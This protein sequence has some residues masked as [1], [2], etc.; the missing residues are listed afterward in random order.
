MLLKIFTK[1]THLKLWSFLSTTIF[2]LY[3]IAH[4]ATTD[5]ITQEDDAI[6]TSFKQF[7]GD[8]YQYKRKQLNG[9]LSNNTQYICV[10]NEHTYVVR[11]LKEPLARRQNEINTHLLA[12]SKGIAPK[13]YYYDDAFSCVILDFIHDHTLLVEQAKRY[14]VLDIIAKKV[15]L[16]TQFDVDILANHHEPD[17]FA[18]IVADYNQIKDCGHTDFNALIDKA[19]HD[20]EII[21]HTLERTRRPSVFNHNDLHPRNIFFTQ[22][23]ILIIDWETAAMNYEFYDLACYSVYSCLNEAED[24]YLLTQYLQ[25]CPSDSDLKEYH[26]VKLMLRVFMAFAFLKLLKPMPQTVPM[27]AVKEFEYYMQ[28][29]A[30]DTNANSPE[31]LYALAISFLQEFFKEYAAF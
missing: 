8:I 19:R 26:R 28:I 4:V 6:F 30:Q 1:K 20:V 15:R 9:G 16:I 22:N 29:F 13:I 3:I 10:V 17:L 7:S 25:D 18:Q 31:F 12:A 21:Y 5:P 24:R 23:D 14:D 27:E 11:A 2:S